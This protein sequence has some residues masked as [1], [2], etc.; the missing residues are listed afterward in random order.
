MKP[1]ARALGV[2]E[3]FR[4]ERSTIGGAVVTASRVTDGFGFRDC[5][6]GGT[7]ATD[8][9]RRLYSGLD[10]ED[11]QYL[12]VAGVALAWYNILDLEALHS[13]VDRPV[14]AITFEASDGLASSL[15]EAFDGA[16]LNR[17]LEAYRAL[18]DREEITVNGES[19]YIRWVGIDEPAARRVV[20]AYT[21]D[22]G[23]PEPVRVARQAA[24]AA[25]EYVTKIDDA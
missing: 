7:D 22:G 21:P 25:D 6:V 9:I 11:V 13:H 23:R 12:L 5:T 14:I 16:A 18:P 2:A 24:R 19:I 1:G 4:G 17:R 20:T 8:A 10:R 15:R 3:S